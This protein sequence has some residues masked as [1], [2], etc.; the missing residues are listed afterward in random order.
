MIEW[1]VHPSI[2]VSLANDLV[3]GVRAAIP[4]PALAAPAGAPDPVFGVKNAFGLA[5]WPQLTLDP[6][7]I[8]RK[9]Y[10]VELVACQAAQRARTF[11][12]GGQH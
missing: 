9:S 12:V 1:C 7:H 5:W 11:T 4:T 3:G 8:G 2:A 6:A 10:W